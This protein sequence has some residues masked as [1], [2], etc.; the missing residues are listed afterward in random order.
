MEHLARHHPAAVAARASFHADTLREVTDAVARYPVV[1]VGMGW[2]PSVWRA[3]S[4]LQK[5]EIPYHYI[6]YGNYLSGWRRR[7]AIKL[8]GYFNPTAVRKLV[9]EHT[10]AQ[11]DHSA[12]L[13]LL[14]VFE[15]WH[16]HFIDSQPPTPNP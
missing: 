4:L 12:R 1:V 6:G 8:R 10:S 11:W 2:N 9:D 3:R 15:L 16:R 7:L 14:L 13:W 5:A